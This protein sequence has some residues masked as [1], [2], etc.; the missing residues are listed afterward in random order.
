MVDH[1]GCVDPEEAKRAF[2]GVGVEWSGAPQRGCGEGEPAGVPAEGDQ[3]RTALLNDALGVGRFATGF[4]P[5][6]GAAKR[7]MTRERQLGTG[8]EDTE[9]VVGGRV[10]RWQD[11]RGFREVRP[12]C[13]GSHLVVCQADC[14]EHDRDRIAE[15]RRV[16]E[17]VYLRELPRCA[18]GGIHRFSLDNRYDTASV[19]RLGAAAIRRPTQQGWE[20]DPVAGEAVRVRGISLGTD[21]GAVAGGED[22]RGLDHPALDAA[23]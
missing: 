4:K 18:G 7:R 10:R 6:V 1:C 9:P 5:G 3:T 23:R 22:V 19:R 15:I 2:Q 13:E 21:Q 12:S 14:V 20:V 16:G 8:G 11:E 17:D